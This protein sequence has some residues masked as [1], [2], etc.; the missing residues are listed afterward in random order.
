MD[1]RMKRRSNILYRLR[2]KGVRCITK[3]RVIFFA[4]GKNPMEIIQIARLCREFGFSVQLE[5][6]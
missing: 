6:I 1:K 3:E 4:Y 5:I 2:K